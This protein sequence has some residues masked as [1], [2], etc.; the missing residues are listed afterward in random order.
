LT[1]LQACDLFLHLFGFAREIFVVVHLSPGRQPFSAGGD[2][3]DFSLLGFMT[4]GIA[5]VPFR[6]R[7]TR[8][9]AGK[10]EGV[11]GS[12]AQDPTGISYSIQ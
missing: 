7:L 6:Q 8:R 3:V 11:Q 9:A 1:L 5:F 10:G 4:Q 2:A 12:V